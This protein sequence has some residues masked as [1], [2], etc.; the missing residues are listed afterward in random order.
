MSTAIELDDERAILAELETVIAAGLESFVAVG[1]ALT[2]VRDERLYLL[3]HESF[4]EYC[5]ERWHLQ[6]AHAYRLIT[7]AGVV[8]NVSHGGHDLPPPT[9]ER[10]AR[11]LAKVPAAEQAEVWAKAVESAP[12]GGVT[13]AHVEAVARSTPTRAEQRAERCTKSATA[14]FVLNL[15][16]LGTAAEALL[17]VLAD[18]RLYGRAQ[19]RHAIKLDDSQRVEAARAIREARHN[20]SMLLKA[21]ES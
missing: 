21:V 4:E 6:R 3:S 1:N 10:Q 12:A 13:A 15:H 18:G 9:K 14:K 7:A 8:E 2:R 20:L 16:G 19:N 17:G 11:A 5:A